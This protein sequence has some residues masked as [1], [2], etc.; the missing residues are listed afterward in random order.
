MTNED[1]WRDGF[2]AAL[3]RT[4]ATNAQINDELET[5]YAAGRERGMTPKGA[6]GDPEQYAASLGYRRKIAN[7][8]EGLAG[9]AMVVGAFVLIDSLRALRTGEPYRLT[10]SGLLS[11]AVILLGIPALLWVFR[12]YSGMV[13]ISA[14]IGMMLLWVF[15]SNA[16][17][18]TLV[19][20]DA[21][22]PTVIGF[23]LCLGAIAYVAA[24]LCH[25]NR[26]P[27]VDP[28]TGQDV[29]FPNPEPTFMQRWGPLVMMIAGLL[30]V[31][32]A[33]AV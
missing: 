22:V 24:Y 21:T 1:A 2:V 3:R 7:L 20:V 27:V 30:V 4:R 15:L 13:V 9:A 33:A 18:A 10:I 28:L 12:R 23:A 32:L 26:N 6:L 11:W 5:A 31:V 25:H 16:R 14:G 8:G 19:S 29:R 17:T